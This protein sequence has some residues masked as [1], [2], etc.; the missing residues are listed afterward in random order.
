MPSPAMLCLDQ[1]H[2][3]NHHQEMGLVPRPPSVGRRRPVRPA[4]PRSW[5]HVG[6]A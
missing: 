1:P 6:W 3:W 5:Q 2:A 4:E